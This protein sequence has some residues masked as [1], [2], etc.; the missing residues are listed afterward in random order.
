MNF[1]SCLAV[2]AAIGWTSSASD[3]VAQGTLPE[4]HK[5]RPPADPNQKICQDITVVGSRLA[6][7]RI[8]ATRAEW[9][10]KRQQD[11]DEVDRI[12]RNL[13]VPTKSGSC[14]PGG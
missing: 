11:K 3:A 13:C 4:S 7:K 8:C 12:Q 10:A 6:T 5:A 14:D 2:I 9:A 1:S